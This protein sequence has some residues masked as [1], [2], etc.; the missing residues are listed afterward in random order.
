[1]CEYTSLEMSRR[2]SEA[3]LKIVEKQCV[4]NDGYYFGDTKYGIEFDDG[5]RTKHLKGETDTDF[6]YPAYRADVLLVWL[7]QRGFFEYLMG[8]KASFSLKRNNGP[9]EVKGYGVPD[10]LGAI[11]LRV[12]ECSR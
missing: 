3:K 5:D 7:L 12:L 2:L 1:M 8:D 10:L 6:S 9:I 11:V 4:V